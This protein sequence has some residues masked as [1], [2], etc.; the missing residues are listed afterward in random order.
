MILSV[1]CR[2]ILIKR[3]YCENKVKADNNRALKE[4]RVALLTE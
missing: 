2:I 4:R 3:L 1:I